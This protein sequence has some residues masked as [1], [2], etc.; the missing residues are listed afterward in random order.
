MK[1]S[2]KAL[3]LSVLVV[4][5]LAGCFKVQVDLKLNENDTIDGSM[6]VAIQAGVGESLGMSDDEVLG[7][8]TEE[9]ES[10]EGM[11]AEP[12]S[13]DGYIG[14]EYI[15]EGRPLDAFKNSEDGS[16]ISITRDGDEFVVDG[17]WDTDDESGEMDPASLGATFTFAV[18]F[19]G[20]VT[21]H[22]GELS[23]DG[24]TVTWNLLD[25]PDTL[26][27]VGGAKAGGGSPLGWI[28]I[29]LGILVIAAVVAVIVV[30]SRGS[31]KAAVAA[32]PAEAAG[33]EG[34]AP[35]AEE[36]AVD[37]PAEAAAESEPE[38]GPTTA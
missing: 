38:D 4:A 33:A 10:E 20:K 28:V 21:D 6:L 9:F 27:A 2:L 34:A 25:G 23:D 26:H 32:A 14:T 13:E 5:T 19:P 16:D 3:A 17:T 8:L 31:K 37:A 35:V 30:R 24:H 36:P 1:N 22:N 29:A 7:Q 11:K 12:Y 18:T 15:F